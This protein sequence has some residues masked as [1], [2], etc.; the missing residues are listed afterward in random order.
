L[1]SAAAARRLQISAIGEQTAR[2]HLS[3]RQENTIMDFEFNTTTAQQ[4]DEFD[5][6]LRIGAGDETEAPQI[7]TAICTV[8][9]TR[10]TN[11]S[12]CSHTSPRFCC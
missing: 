5:I 12:T 4:N 1:P 11:G 8:P 3:L 2:R 7:A 9:C 6:D 10:I